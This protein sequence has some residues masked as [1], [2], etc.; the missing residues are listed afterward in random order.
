MSGTGEKHPVPTAGRG[1]QRLAGAAGEG[2]QEI[3]SEQMGS[4]LPWLPRLT[5]RID[6]NQLTPWQGKRPGQ[7]GAG[8]GWRAPGKSGVCRPVGS[9]AFPRV[10]K[11]MAEAVVEPLAVGVGRACPATED[12]KRASP[13]PSSSSQRNQP[14]RGTQESLWTYPLP[15]KDLPPPSPV[16]PPHTCL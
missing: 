5:Q 2:R 12:G 7:N 4:M 8:A 14:P 13:E 10:I 6:C 9:G 1:G 3:R 11:E 16:K 15:S